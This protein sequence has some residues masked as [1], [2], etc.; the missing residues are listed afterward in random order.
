MLNIQ[1]LTK[2]QDIAARASPGAWFVGAIPGAVIGGVIGGFGFG[3]ARGYY[4]GQLG[5]S[6]VKYFH[7][8]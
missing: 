6:V 1:T 3:M 7:G 4:G 2:A 8:R 5:E